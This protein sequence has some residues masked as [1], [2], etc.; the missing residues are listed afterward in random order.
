MKY[1]TKYYDERTLFLTSYFLENVGAYSKI[2]SGFLVQQKLILMYY[3]KMSR[4]KASPDP[5]FSFSYPF[6]LLHLTGFEPSYLILHH[7]NFKSKT[8]LDFCRNTV[9]PNRWR[10]RQIGDCR[11]RLRPFFIC[12][13]A[14][15]KIQFLTTGTSVTYHL[16]KWREQKQIDTRTENRERGTQDA[17][18][19]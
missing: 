15:L 11:T 12:I 13:I 2:T 6:V 7:Q 16:L 9:H 3:L 19:S 18:A 8:S 14:K 4:T 5:Q 1:V 17:A 10:C